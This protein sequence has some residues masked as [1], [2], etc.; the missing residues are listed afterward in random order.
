MMQKVTDP[1][2]SMLRSVVLTLGAARQ[3]RPDRFPTDADTAPATDS[4]SLAI[5]AS[6][7][8]PR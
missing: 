8:E 3:L 2:G 5:P 7:A 4:A 6:C 1:S